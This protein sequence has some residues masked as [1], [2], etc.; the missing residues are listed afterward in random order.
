MPRSLAGAATG[1]MAKSFGGPKDGERVT[2][3]SA[4]R[5]QTK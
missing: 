1:R 3:N 2:E 5:N 4:E